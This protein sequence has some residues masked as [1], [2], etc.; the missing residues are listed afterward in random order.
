MASLGGVNTVN[1]AACHAAPCVNESQNLENS[2]LFSLLA[3][4]SSWR[5]VRWRLYPPPIPSR[6]SLSTIRLGY[7]LP[8]RT[9]VPPLC[10]YLMLCRLG[11]GFIAVRCGRAFSSQTQLRYSL[12]VGGI[13][14][15]PSH[16]VQS[17]SDHLRY[18]HQSSREAAALSLYGMRETL[19]DH[20]SPG[21]RLEDDCRREGQLRPPPGAYGR[22]CYVGSS[23]DQY[24]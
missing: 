13:A 15:S 22:G 21:K 9:I 20:N 3:G 19:R 2:L 7:P 16:P 17:G 6:Q 24:P 1:C 8:R 18:Q 12:R 10:C 23:A 14:I 11:S 4:N 5:R